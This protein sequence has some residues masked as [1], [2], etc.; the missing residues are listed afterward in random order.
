MKN[1]KIKPDPEGEARLIKH[2]WKKLDI[3]SPW[4]WR[5]PQFQG[6]YLYKDALDIVASQAKNKQEKKK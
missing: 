5:E 2:G 4:R 6:L 3:F 1:T